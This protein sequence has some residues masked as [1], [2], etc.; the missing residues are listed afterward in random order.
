[1]RNTITL[2]PALAFEKR[3]YN[4]TLNLQAF[5]E[6][7]TGAASGASSSASA[8]GEGAALGSSSSA[9]S[10]GTSATPDAKAA[11]KGE[12]LSR[13]AKRQARAAGQM[14]SEKNPLAAVKYGKQEAVQA[15]AEPQTTKGKQGEK[16]AAENAKAS[17]EKN[18]AFEKMIRGEYKDQFASRTQSIIN[19]RFKETKQLEAKSQK[20]DALIEGLARRY[21]VNAND[22]DA[23]AKAAQTDESYTEKEARSRGLSVDEMRR[24]KA[25]ESENAR[26]RS[27]DNARTARDAANKVYQT[28][29]SD[30]EKLKTVYPD[31]DFKKEVQNPDF[32]KLLKSGVSVRKAY[33]T[34]HLDTIL[35]GA[36]QYT[37]DQ[38]A[39]GVVS[40]ISDRASRPA[41]NGTTPRAGAVVKPNVAGLS[42]ADR[43]E[44]ERRVMRGERILF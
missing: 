21:G 43:E 38:V 16:A 44:I 2:L 19:Q 27:K 22:L 15:A 1:M 37:A 26:L 6:G 28:W 9:A 33:E 24:V 8:A 32:K 4:P 11:P 13:A 18:V 40:R 41:E 12:E 14:P 36:M 29:L 42:R 10:E 17:Q 39:K 31:F 34:S 5:A 7:G 23:I 25:L 35:G 30:G 20:A 3:C